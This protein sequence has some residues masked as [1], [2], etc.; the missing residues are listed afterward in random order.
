MF[1]GQ[2]V[3]YADFLAIWPLKLPFPGISYARLRL[4]ILRH[5]YSTLF[6]SPWCD[7]AERLTGGPM[8]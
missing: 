5:L 1:V 7:Q 2:K 4:A 8:N 3:R 6:L